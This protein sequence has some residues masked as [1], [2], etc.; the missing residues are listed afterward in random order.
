MGGIDVVVPCYQYGRF[1]AESVNSILS[2]P[3]EDLRVLIVDNG[4]TDNTLE[5]AKE[6]AERRCSGANPGVQ[7]EP[8]TACELQCRN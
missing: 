7:D 5:V 8:W 4:S 2:Q 1:L 6:I 3:V